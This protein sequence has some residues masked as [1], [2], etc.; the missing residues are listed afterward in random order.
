M[1]G[2]NTDIGNNFLNEGNPKLALDFWDYE[3]MSS[4]FTVICF[5]T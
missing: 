4:Y 5:L 2:F 3:F 1:K